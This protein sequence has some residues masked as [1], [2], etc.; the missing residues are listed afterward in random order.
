[1]TNAGAKTPR[2]NQAI[3]PWRV[4]LTVLVVAVVAFFLGRS[5][6]GQWDAVRSQPWSVNL[7]WLLGSGLVTW[8]GVVWL[9]F[10][11]RS[12]IVLLSSRPLPFWVAYR[13][14][15]LANLGKYLPGK[16]WSVMGLIYFLKEE[17]HPAPAAL[18]AT[19][20]HQAYTLVSG[21]L[22]VSVVLGVGVWGTLPIAIAGA[23]IAVALVVLY[24]PVFER[25]LNW[26]LKILRRDPVVVRISFAR[27]LLLYVGYTL[28]WVVYG[29]G[30][31]MMSKGLGID[32]GP[33]W[34]VVAS[35]CGAYLVGFLALFA[36]GGLGVREGV[37]AVMLGPHLQP[38]LP[39]TVAVIS[40]L[41]MTVIELFGL[42]PLVFMRKSK[43]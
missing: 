28:A 17:G 33:F 10:L 38:G 23:A 21:I 37:L 12:V 34:P 29:A 22:F 27:A 18:A 1:M 32:A 40:R 25:V 39:A 2:T 8:L 43:N 16:I 4:A 7:P 14:A 9:M 5:I 3:R 15:S 13:I 42:L 24:P 31:W 6:A 20:L 41:W 35:Y 11:W 19:I 36:P 30:F 26:G